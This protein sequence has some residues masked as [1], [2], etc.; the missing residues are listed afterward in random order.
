M[1]VA[2][3]QPYFLPYIGYFQLMGAV[4]VFVVYDNIEYTKKGWINRN[5]LLQNGAAA[6]FSLP[7]RNGH[8]HLHVCQ[9]QLAASFDRRKLLNQ[10][11]GAYAKAP[12][13]GSCWP[14]LEQ[15]VL[16][17]AQNLF[18]YIH[19]SL[20]CMGHTLGI[21]TP[22]VVS[23]GIP[24]DHQQL[25][26]QEKVLAICAELGA[27]TYI[28]PVG[29]TTLYDPAAFA[30]RGI[31][32]QFL[33]AQPQPYPQFGAPFVPW[34]SIVDVLMFNEVEEVQRHVQEKYH[35]LSENTLPF[36]A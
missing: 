35:F 6:T 27:S 10:L 15:I 2:I 4:D 17:P 5:R 12:A 28:N 9:R 26:A 1:R 33:Q 13:F 7:L 14:A 34:L 24:I 31:K 21:K 22:L 30:K 8:D 36:N 16:C 19:H 18:D 23:S 3:M 20:L 29:G 32:L 25:R 11:R